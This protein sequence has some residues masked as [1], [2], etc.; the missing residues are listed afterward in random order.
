MRLSVYMNAPTEP[1][2]LELRNGME[3]L[4]YHSHELIIYSRKKLFKVN[5]SS[6]QCFFKSGS[7]YIKQNQE[8]SNFLHTYCESDHARYISDRC[9]VTSTVNLFNGTIIDWRTNK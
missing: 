5:D 2:F 7:A 8:Y 3:Y 9:Y 1:D 4:M 6:N